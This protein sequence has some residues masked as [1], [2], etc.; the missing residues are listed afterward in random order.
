MEV[1]NEISDKTVTWESPNDLL[2]FWQSRKHASKKK[3]T[4]AIA[5]FPWAEYS[6]CSKMYQTTTSTHHSAGASCTDYEQV[7]LAGNFF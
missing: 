6:I 3:K 1:A 7:V 4:F 2:M 5:S